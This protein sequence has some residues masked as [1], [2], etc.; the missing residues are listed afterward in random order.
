MKTE[1]LLVQVLWDSR[2]L[3]AWK[4]LARG[5][6]QCSSWPVSLTLYSWP[7]TVWELGALALQAMENPWITYHWPSVSTVLPNP[8]LCIWWI[9]PTSGR[10]VLQDLLLKKDP[11]ISGLAQFKA[12][13][14]KG[15]L[16]TIYMENIHSRLWGPFGGSF[17][18]THGTS[19]E[20]RV[21]SSVRTSP[22]HLELILLTLTVKALFHAAESWPAF[23]C[24][25]SVEL[26]VQER[27]DGS[28]ACTSWSTVLFIILPVITFNS[29]ITGLCSWASA[30][31]P[32]CP[33]GQVCILTVPTSVYF[34]F[35]AWAWLSPML[36]KCIREIGCLGDYIVFN[37]PLG[38]QYWFLVK[39]K[40]FTIHLSIHHLSIQPAT[41][42]SKYPFIH[43]FIHPSMHPSKYPTIYPSNHPIIEKKCAIRPTLPCLFMGDK[44]KEER[45]WLENE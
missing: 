27:T 9:Q 15:Q 45:R 19:L 5:S 44:K 2:S 30:P 17:V 40:N 18:K 42:L 1:S 33:W 22:W 24:H 12:L 37:K 28:S 31:T 21:P 11:C 23:D 20:I 10:V 32:S 7:C 43:P 3:T 34:Q 36:H 13:L 39:H 26:P 16:W 14:I 25:P 29:H 38:Y 35:L 8:R 6:P 4:P 41:H